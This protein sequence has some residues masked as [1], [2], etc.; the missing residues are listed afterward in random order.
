MDAIYY[1]TGL[2]VM[3]IIIVILALIAIV[4][5]SILFW[6]IFE[7]TWIYETYRV[8]RLWYKYIRTGTL[9]PVSIA[10]LRMVKQQIEQ[11]KGR[12]QF[13]PWRRWFLKFTNDQIAAQEKEQF[14][15]R[16]EI[17]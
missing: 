17:I 2:I 16:G 6:V 10:K 4:Y 12:Y 7:R 11:K 5:L 1:Y 15:K 14:E 9:V 13:N 8:I 3:W